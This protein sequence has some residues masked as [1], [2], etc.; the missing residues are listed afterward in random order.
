MWLRVQQVSF[1]IIQSHLPLCFCTDNWKFN[2]NNKHFLITSVSDKSRI[3]FPVVYSI[4]FCGAWV[5]H[6]F[7]IK[8]CDHSKFLPSST[9]DSSSFRFHADTFW[10]HRVC[11][12]AV[13]LQLSSPLFSTTTAKCQQPCSPAAGCLCASLCVREMSHYHFAQSDLTGSETQVP[14]PIIQHCLMRSRGHGAGVTHQC[15]DGPETTRAHIYPQTIFVT[16]AVFHILKNGKTM[17]KKTTVYTYIF[18]YR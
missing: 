2:P 7:E 10:R 1:S 13:R 16:A 15:P 11:T 12:S 8:L 17:Q 9:D 3:K 6:P 5:K 14:L 18:I 4:F